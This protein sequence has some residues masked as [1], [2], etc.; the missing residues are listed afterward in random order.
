MPSAEYSK[1]LEEGIREIETNY[2][3]NSS[4]THMIYLVKHSDV[5]ELFFN[6]G[7]T[8]WK[9]FLHKKS[10]KIIRQK[11]GVAFQFAE[12]QLFKATILEDIAFGPI[13][14]GMSKEKAYEL[15]RKC[16]AT[17]GMPAE[18]EQRSPFELSGGQKRRVA[19]AGILAMQPDCLV[20]DEPTAGLDPKG[21]VEILDILSD[22]HKQGKTII[23]VT[24]DLDNILERANRILLLK[25]GKLILDDT[26]YNVLNN[27]P[28]L[29]ENNLQPPKIL[30]FVHE[31]R[32]KGIP[33][34]EVHSIE[35][36]ASYLTKYRKEKNE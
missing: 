4:L 25:D 21:V 20:V 17:V 14:F 29:I 12:Y 7:K 28:L 34:P 6:A 32:L 13:A 33:V 16:L 22:L 19:L 18:Y 8:E 23:N 11:V 24:H 3:K 31:L 36:L 5:G 15:A 1:K 35:E 9:S 27:V 30:E 10:F 2:V 26:P